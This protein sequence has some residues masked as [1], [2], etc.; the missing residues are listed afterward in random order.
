MKT[1]EIILAQ[2]KTDEV[3]QAT[4]TAGA[5]LVYVKLTGVIDISLTVYKLGNTPI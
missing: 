3:L 4:V 1:L 2:K 5:S